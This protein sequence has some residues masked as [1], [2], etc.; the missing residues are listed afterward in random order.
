LPELLRARNLGFAGR[1][2][3]V[4]DLPARDFPVRPPARFTDLET[5]RRCLVDFFAAFRDLAD[6]FPEPL[7]VLD[8]R[9]F[10]LGKIVWPRAAALPAK[11]P[12][13]PPT[14]APTGPA[15]LPIAAPVTA[16]AVCFEISGSWMFSEDC[17][18]PL[19]CALG[20]SGIS[21]EAPSVLFGYHQKV[22]R[23]A[24]IS[25]LSVNPFSKINA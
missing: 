16:P 18:L 19:F 4:R 23:T 11:A 15:T 3:L 24:S 13:T 21:R 9:G 17:A 6:L 5:G 8:R 7:F 20:S 1:V 22:I 12:T 14:T 10:A 2:F 25:Q